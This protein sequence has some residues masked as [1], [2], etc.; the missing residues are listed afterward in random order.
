M[1]HPKVAEVFGKRKGKDVP[2]SMNIGIDGSQG[3]VVH[4]II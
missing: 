1:G 2:A 3:L 4:S